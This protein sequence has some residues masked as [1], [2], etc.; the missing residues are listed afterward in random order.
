MSIRNNAAAAFT[1]SLKELD[2]DSKEELN[3]D[4]L[5]LAIEQLRDLRD[6][7][8]SAIGLLALEL[9]AVVTPGMAL[10]IPGDI[11]EALIQSKGARAELLERLKKYRDELAKKSDEST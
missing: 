6:D 2:A 10:H 11:G 8:R 4:E 5:I 7:L 3:E 9:D 1:L